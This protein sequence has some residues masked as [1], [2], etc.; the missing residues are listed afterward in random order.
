M[1]QN[2]ELKNM[3]EY[4]KS[5][6]PNDAHRYIKKLTLATVECLPDPYALAAEDWEDNINKFP[7]ITWHNVTESES[8]TRGV[9]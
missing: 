8:A 7:G 3:S 5:V 1:N 2:K 4:L 6:E 9:L